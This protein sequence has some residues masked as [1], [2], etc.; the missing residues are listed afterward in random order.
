MAQAWQ[1]PQTR[2]EVG[3]GAYKVLQGVHVHGKGVRQVLVVHANLEVV[4]PF[5]HAINR[6]QLSSH[7][8]QERGLATAIQPNYG[9]PG[10]QVHTEINL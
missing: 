2:A 8:L 4:V 7:E 3:R 9:Y 10:V 5:H 1:S 6:L